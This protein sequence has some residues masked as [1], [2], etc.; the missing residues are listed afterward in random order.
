MERVKRMWIDET[1][2]NIVESGYEVTSEPNEEYN[3]IAWAAGSDSEWW[4]HVTGYRWPAERVSEVEALIQ[5]FASMGYEVCDSTE[6]EEGFEKV[7]VFVQDGRWSHAARQLDNGQW[8]SKLGIFED[9][10]HSTVECLAG[11][12]YGDVHCTMRRLLG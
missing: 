12:F 8:T 5:V 4:S 2:P 7:V 1:F 11:D 10:E 3:C 9:I 6:R